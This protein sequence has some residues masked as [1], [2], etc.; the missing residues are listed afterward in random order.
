MDASSAVCLRVELPNPEVRTGSKEGD[1]HGCGGWRSS[2]DPCGVE[3][4]VDT[5]AEVGFGG[6]RCDPC[7]GGLWSLGNWATSLQEHVVKLG[8]DFHGL[9]FEICFSLSRSP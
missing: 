3:L 2:G 6:G 9:P 7:L 8:V 5:Q 4:V 1:G